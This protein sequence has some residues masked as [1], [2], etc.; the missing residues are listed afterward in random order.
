MTEDSQSTLREEPLMIWGTLGQ[1]RGKKLNCY[2]L[3]EKNQ[4]N[5]L[6]EKKLNSTTWKKKIIMLFMLGC[7][8]LNMDIHAFYILF[9]YK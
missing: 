8:A 5:N 1:K 9:R 4:L 2:L 7:D 3:G 6:D